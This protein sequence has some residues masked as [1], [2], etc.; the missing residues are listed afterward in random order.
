MATNRRIFIQQTA[1]GLGA[2]GATAA[3][4]TRDRFQRRWQQILALTHISSR[5]LSSRRIADA[6]PALSASGL[7]LFY[8]LLTDVAAAAPSRDYTAAI[9]PLERFIRNEMT[10]KEL[11]GLSIAL[12]DDQHTVWSQ[13][14]GFADPVARVPAT[15]ETVH[16]AGSVS[17]LFTDIAIMQL[18][19]QGRLELDAPVSRYLP[20]FRPRNPFGTPITLRQLMTHRSGLVREPPL[21]RYFDTSEPSLARSVASLNRTALVYAPGTRT[22]YSNAGIAVVGLVLERMQGERFAQALKHALLDPL[23]MARSSFDP[24]PE[25]RKDLAKAYIWTEYGRTFEAP[26]FE[27]G[28]APAGSLPGL[29]WSSQRSLCSDLTSKI[30]IAVQSD[31]N[32]SEVSSRCEARSW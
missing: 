9:E 20:E 12:V 22:K 25:I 16:G 18:V 23:G 29:N 6:L 27:P 10:D 32:A 1:L 4:A 19:E 15:A 5:H 8:G 11:P 2:V 14:F 7:V 30:F 3:R 13:G 26:T 24:N 28:I 31:A 17:K 21:G